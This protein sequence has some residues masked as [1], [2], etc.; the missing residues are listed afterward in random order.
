MNPDGFE[1]VIPFDRRSVVEA[2]GGEIDQEVERLGKCDAQG[3]NLA[4]RR[5]DG[6]GGSV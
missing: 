6:V 1:A 4:Q 3:F 2:A 5:D